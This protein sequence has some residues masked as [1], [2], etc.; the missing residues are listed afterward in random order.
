MDFYICYLFTLFITYKIFQV[1]HSTCFTYFGLKSS[2]LNGN[3]II[4]IQIYCKYKRVNGFEG[5]S[6]TIFVISEFCNKMFLIIMYR[7]F[8][9][10][11]LL[12]RCMH[13]LCSESTLT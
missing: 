4:I 6:I 7:V 12:K 13:V 9:Y 3:Y 10:A 11:F 8:T 1:S 5:E 2:L